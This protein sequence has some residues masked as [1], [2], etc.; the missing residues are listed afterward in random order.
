[1]FPAEFTAGFTAGE[2]VTHQAELH[3]WW[4]GLFLMQRTTSAMRAGWGE[5]CTRRLQ[6]PRRDRRSRPVVGRPPA[7][8]RVCLPLQIDAQS[9]VLGCRA[10]TYMRHLVRSYAGRVARCGDCGVESRADPRLMWLW[11]SNATDRAH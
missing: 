10:T 4:V 7:P 6:L 1:M 8:R 3:V 9:A 11:L 5:G 2:H